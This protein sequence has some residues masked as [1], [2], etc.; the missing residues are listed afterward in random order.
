MAKYGPK[1][2]GLAARPLLQSL[3][4]RFGFVLA[5]AQNGDGDCGGLERGFVTP[6]STVGLKA[7]SGSRE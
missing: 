1:S 2:N 4:N 6:I 3:E 5:L 7:T